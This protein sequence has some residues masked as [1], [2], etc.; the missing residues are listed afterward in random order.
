MSEL[1][2]TYYQSPIGLIKISGTETYITEVT[3]IDK[4]EDIIDR[5][6]ST[7]LLQQCVEELIAYFNGAARKFEIPVYKQGTAF[8]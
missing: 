4:P 8:Q 3:F 2:F 6:E 1:A 7:P 5:S